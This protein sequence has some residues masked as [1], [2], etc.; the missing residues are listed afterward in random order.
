M[1]VGLLA[2]LVVAVTVAVS[3]R[4]RN[5]AD[6][7]RR[8]QAELRHA[9]ALGEQLRAAQAESLVDGTVNAQTNS[10]AF[11]VARNLQRSVDRLAG[12][13]VDP[14]IVSELRRTLGGLLAAGT[15]ALRLG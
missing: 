7:Q 3:E 1:A 15:R 5:T 8:A 13:G 2:V 11:E 12:L 9:Q 4:A 14:S 10:E 6:D